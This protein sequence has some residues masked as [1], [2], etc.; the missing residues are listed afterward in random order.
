VEN[1]YLISVL[2][3]S[4]YIG[5]WENVYR[6]LNQNNNI[7]FELIWV[8]PIP[9][10]ENALKNVKFIKT[11]V[12]PSQC[13]EIAARLAKGKYLLPSCDDVMFSVS[14]LNKI[15][16]T[17]L[18]SSKI[19]IIY[20][21]YRKNSNAA[22]KQRVDKKRKKSP[23]AGLISVYDRKIWR[24]IGGIDRRFTAI[25]WSY[26]LQMRFFELGGKAI[27]AKE[28]YSKEKS[29]RGKKS[30]TR[31]PRIASKDKRLFNEL[32]YDNINRKY[33]TKRSS[34]V[35]SFSDKKILKISQGEKGEDKYWK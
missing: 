3:S 18:T 29:H 6:S 7:P 32:W 23:I 21:K 24:K 27:M 35:Y 33:S 15:Y 11:H 26:D 5:L 8:G 30:L 9:I 25:W 20:T 12:K 16:E 14:F 1:K 10:K 34:P 2:V 22:V 17:I 13:W 31:T 19:D 4:K 28:C